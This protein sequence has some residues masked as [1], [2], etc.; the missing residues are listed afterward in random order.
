MVRLDALRP[1]IH[2]L[3]WSGA[4]RTW[5]LAE[6]LPACSPRVVLVLMGSITGEDNPLSTTG[7]I[8]GIITLLIG[9][10]TIIQA[11]VT[12]FAAYRDAPAELNRFTSSISN[13]IDEN[14]HRL[15]T[16]H[17][18]G[19]ISLDIGKGGYTEGRWAEMLQEYYNAHLELDEELSKIKRESD[20][21]NSLFN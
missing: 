12:Y 19:L 20:K 4:D 11:L 16:N 21:D 5:Q 8:V 10:S 3:V 7:S 2:H 15:R 9:F 1:S 17:I 6:R 14:S 18:P 13:T